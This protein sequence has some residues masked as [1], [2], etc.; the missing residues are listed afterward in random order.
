MTERERVLLVARIFDLL[1]DVL[2]YGFYAWIVW[3]VVLSMRELAGKSTDARFV[4]EYFFS[5]E[6][7]YALPWVL[8]T[9][10]TIW[11]LLE[12]RFRYQKTEQLTARTKELEQRLDPSRSSSGLA[13]TG[14]THPRDKWVP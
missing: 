13:T 2:R 10:A 1:K 12:R 5:R 4:F 6:N 8:A 7:D 9:V 11:A 3:G 14:V